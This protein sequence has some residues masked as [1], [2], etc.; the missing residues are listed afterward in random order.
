MD[1]I[2]LAVQQIPQWM[3]IAAGI[4]VAGY[5]CALVMVEDL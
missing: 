3:H 5:V 4:L 2:T 1:W